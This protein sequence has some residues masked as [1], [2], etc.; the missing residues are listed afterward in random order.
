MLEGTARSITAFFSCTAGWRM[1]RGF[2]NRGSRFS[3]SHECPLTVCDRSWHGHGVIG[4]FRSRMPVEK[5]TYQ[6]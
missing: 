6:R 4:Q 3:C 2:L 5:L 1:A